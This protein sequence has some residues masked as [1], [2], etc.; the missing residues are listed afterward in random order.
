ML[1]VCMHQASASATRRRRHHAGDHEHAYG[2]LCLL[3]T[4]HTVVADQRRAHLLGAVTRAYRQL[5]ATLVQTWRP[6]TFVRNITGAPQRLD[7]LTLLELMRQRLRPRE[8]ALAAAQAGLGA[9]A[10]P[11]ADAARIHAPVA[12]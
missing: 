1:L 11:K 4:V 2:E 9:A 12:I 10:E 5:V 7:L 8:A 6:E 3:C